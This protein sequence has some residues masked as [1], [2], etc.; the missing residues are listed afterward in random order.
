IWNSKPSVLV[1]EPTVVVV[2]PEL[3]LFC[4]HA[5]PS[6]IFVLSSSTVWKDGPSSLN[7]PSGFHTTRTPSRRPFLP[8]PA[9]LFLLRPS[10]LATAAYHSH[11]PLFTVPQPIAPGSYSGENSTLAMERSA[12]DVA[13]LEVSISRPNGNLN[14]PS[15]TL[16]PL[17]KLQFTK[18]S[19]TLI[20]PSLAGSSIFL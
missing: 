10:P 7:A 4:I 13:A 3:S 17:S 20:E 9:V 18:V 12:S 1:S 2:R 5:A 15:S 8:S 11:V 16:A 14:W 6:P 19:R